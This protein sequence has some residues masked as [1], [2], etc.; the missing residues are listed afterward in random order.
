MYVETILCYCI[1]YSNLS[2]LLPCCG[3]GNP[4]C[5]SRQVLFSSCNISLF[6]QHHCRR[7]G[8]I[9]CGDCSSRSIAIPRF[10][11]PQPVRVCDKCFETS[12]RE[13]KFLLEFQPFLSEGGVLVRYTRAEEPAPIIVKLS[14]D[15]KRLTWHTTQLVRNQPQQFDSLSLDNVNEVITG[16]EG[17]VFQCFQNMNYKNNHC[18]SI[19]VNK[20]GGGFVALDMEA[21]SEE[22]RNKWVAGIR[23][24]IEYYQ[25]EKSSF[26]RSNSNSRTNSSSNHA[27]SEQEKRVAELEKREA[28]LQRRER[29]REESRKKRTEDIKAKYNL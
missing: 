14:T 16:A 2:Q 20:P 1:F 25:G 27:T 8:R 15:T 18:F 24:A 9:Y 6:L 29:E 11:F 3:H 5:I 22:E 4:P 26:V 12:Q 19:I 7:D 13:N 21:N 28:E 17:D 23:C 10:G